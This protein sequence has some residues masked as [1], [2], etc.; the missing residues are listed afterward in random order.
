MAQTREAL[1]NEIAKQAKIYKKIEETKASIRLS[2]EQLAA[3]HVDLQKDKEKRN[4]VSLAK[5][6][7]SISITFAFDVGIRVVNRVPGPNGY[8]D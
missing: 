6:L 2:E 7:C 1:N 3:S 5:I 8:P 4:Q